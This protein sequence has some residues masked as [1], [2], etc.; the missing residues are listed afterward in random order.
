[1]TESTDL[2]PTHGK[3]ADSTLEDG[4]TENNTERVSTDRATDNRDRESGK[5]AK[6]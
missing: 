3:T 6:E 2:V 1:M 4:K 5:T